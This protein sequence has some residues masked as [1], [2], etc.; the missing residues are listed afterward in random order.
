MKSLSSLVIAGCLR[1]GH[2]FSLLVSTVKTTQ[3]KEKLRELVKRG[4][5]LLTKDTT[6]S[7]GKRSHP[8]RIFQ[9]KWA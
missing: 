6:L 9:L 3:R 7:A 8:L 2:K 1:N 5:A 4:P